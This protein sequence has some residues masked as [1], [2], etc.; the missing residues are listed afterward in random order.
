MLAIVSEEY[1]R[2]GGSL[3][4]PMLPLFQDTRVLAQLRNDL[5][6]CWEAAFS[7]PATRNEEI[8]FRDKSD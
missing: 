3:L 5:G 1:W 4:M 7:A 8:E 2:S 6:N